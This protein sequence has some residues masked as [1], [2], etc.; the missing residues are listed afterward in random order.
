MRRVA[1]VLI[2]FLALA[3]LIGFAA[4]LGGLGGGNDE[5]GSGD[6][7]AVTGSTGGRAPAEGFDLATAPDEAG[8]DQ[9]GSV[10]GT[11]SDFPLLPEIGPSVI[12]T[13]QIAVEV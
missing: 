11:M 1:L 3:G 12:R 8:R 5:A 13:A 6:F 9:G 2:G 10:G 7:G 4:T